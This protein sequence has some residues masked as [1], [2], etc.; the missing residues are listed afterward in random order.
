M[1]NQQSCTLL[2]SAFLSDP[3]S[4]TSLSNG[5]TSSSFLWNPPAL[6]PPSHHPHQTPSLG[7]FRADV[8][9][10]QIQV[11]QSKVLLKAFG[12]GL[13][14]EIWTSS[15]ALLIK[16]W[17]LCP[18]FLL[19]NLS[20]YWTKGRGMRHNETQRTGFSVSML[21]VSFNL[22]FAHICS[23]TALERYL[24]NQ[25]PM[26]TAASLTVWPPQSNQ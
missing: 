13:T 15:P 23:P 8:V 4:T 10:L 17:V 14:G 22:K 26:Q 12:Q 18:P 19:E 25:D 16:L 1:W 9:K 7:P 3:F 6:T 2:K 11:R 21:Y 24:P 5:C 20:G